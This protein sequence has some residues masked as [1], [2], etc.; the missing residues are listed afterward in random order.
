[1]IGC[2]DV[3]EVKSAPAFN[4]VPGSRLVAVM[5][6]TP[7]RVRDYA[8][9]HGVP[10][11]YTD[12]ERLVNDPEVNAVYI[13]TPPSSHAQYAILAAQAG[14]AV[15]VEKPMAHTVADC[16]RMIA[17]CRRAGVPL[18]VAYYRRYQERFLQVKQWL[19]EGRIGEVR[20]VNVDLWLPPRPE[21]L[22]PDNLPWRVR[23]EISGGGYFHDMA[24]HQLDLLDDW[25]GPLTEARGE[26]HNRAGWYP[27]PDVVLARFRLPDGGLGQGSW[28]FCAS[29]PVDRIEIVGSRGLIR[30]AAFLPAP[31]ELVTPEGIE[32][33]NLIPAQPVAK[34]LIERVVRAL[35]GMGDCS[36]TGETALRTNEVMEAICGPPATDRHAAGP[37]DG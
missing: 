6:R 35:R 21:D 19:R 7:E 2:G 12:A 31:V 1:M 20:L 13:A 28:C 16:R 23:P 36:T 8:R 9:R 15:Y 37:A 14:K 17:A 25:F 30:V 27:A 11:W 22:P 26:T 29:Q 33:R 5:A 18:Y 24:S 10:H 3:T 34:P 4:Q 32:Q